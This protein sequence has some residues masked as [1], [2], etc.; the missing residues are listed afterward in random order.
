MSVNSIPATIVSETTTIANDDSV[1]MLKKAKNAVRRA[2]SPSPAPRQRVSE[3]Q[4]IN[5]V[6][7]AVQSLRA[8]LQAEL[9]GTKEEMLAAGI[10]IESFLGFIGSERLRWMPAK[11]SRWDK[12]LKWAEYFATSLSLFEEAV[13]T[14]VASSQEAVELIFACLQI[15]LQVSTSHRQ[16]I[17]LSQPLL[18]FVAW[19]WS[20]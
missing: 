16:A 14:F 6:H 5:N 2:V 18:T 20:R 9:K 1:G 17:G 11:G 15:L 12:I 3:S 4:F 10:T 13:E 19:S 7:E 8:R